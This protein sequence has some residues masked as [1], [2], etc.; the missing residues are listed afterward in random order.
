MRMRMPPNL[1]TD[2]IVAVALAGLGVFGSLAERPGP[3]RPRPATAAGTLARLRREL[4]DD[5]P[6]PD[7]APED[8][9]GYAPGYAPEDA[10]VGA[11][12]GTPVG[13]LVGAPRGGWEI[14]KRVWQRIADHRIMS[15]AAG[16]TFYALL[17]IFPAM[18][19]LISL[20]GLVA[21]PVAISQH[22]DDVE[23]FVPSGGMD[24]LRDE[25][26]RLVTAG[27]GA[28]GF[29]AIVGI[30]VALWSANGGTKAMFDSLNVVYDEKEKRSYVGRTAV[31][32]ALTL[33]VLVV[34]ILALASVVALPIA[35]N[36][37]GLTAVTDILVRVARWP[38]MMLVIVVLLAVL[39]RYGPSRQEPKWRWATWGSGFAAVAW[40]IV[41]IGFSFYVGHFSSYSKTYGSLGA[42][43]G[44]MTW[45]WISA[46]VVLA[47][48]EIDAEMERRAAR[49]A[50]IGPPQRQGRRGATKARE[51]A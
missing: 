29:G 25:I 24:I 39:Y 48:A 49:H 27:S 51:A 31:S 4:R 18:A 38:V 15:E 44:F 23:G 43:V 3:A 37:V 21:D 12:V 16:V 11:P 40:V 50:P 20:F 8:A 33:G 30:L 10:P 26:R 5:P 46:M 14:L 41:S 6:R 1:R 2:L 17:A 19:A 36:F 32:L 34:V 47:G 35:L 13:A 22:L 9:P 7:D 28:L 42:A 45:I